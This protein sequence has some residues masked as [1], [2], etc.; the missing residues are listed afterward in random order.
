M[1]LLSVDTCHWVG[2]VPRVYQK[3]GKQDIFSSISL[4]HTI[5]TINY[6][7]VNLTLSLYYFDGMWN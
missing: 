7:Y 6:D 3:I 1:C 5:I 4:W 2:K